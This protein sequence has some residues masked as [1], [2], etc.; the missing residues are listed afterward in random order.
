MRGRVDPL[1]LPD[2]NLC[3]NLRGFQVGVAEHLLDVAD[4]G[5]VLQHECRKTMAEHVAGAPLPDIRGVHVRTDKVA[6]V[7]QTERLAGVRQKHRVI[8]RLHRKL[9]T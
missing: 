3:V 6:Q 2:R 5:A 4:V 1:Q 8:V 7:I 9:R